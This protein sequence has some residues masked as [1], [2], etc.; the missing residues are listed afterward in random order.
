MA[1]IHKGTSSKGMAAAI[2]Q[3]HYEPSTPPSLSKATFHQV[4]TFIGS[5]FGEMATTSPKATSVN[6]KTG[7]FQNGDSY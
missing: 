2:E 6:Q 4:G 7:K 1:H 3:G 5:E